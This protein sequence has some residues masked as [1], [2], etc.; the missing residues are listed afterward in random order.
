MTHNNAGILIN[1]QTSEVETSR[2]YNELKHKL[3]T[4][5]SEI[6]RC[7]LECHIE[8]QV[9]LVGVVITLQLPVNLPLEETVK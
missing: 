3:Y 9:A 2:D 1:L 4:I 7:I 8:T 6:V 5:N